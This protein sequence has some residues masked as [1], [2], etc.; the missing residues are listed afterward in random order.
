MQSSGLRGRRRTARVD[1][2]AE[3]LT[4]AGEQHGAQ[5]QEIGSVSL[6]GDYVDGLPAEIA[7]HGMNLEVDP[8]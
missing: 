6:L 7:D 3:Q 2:D 5:D 8:R 4:G 1:G